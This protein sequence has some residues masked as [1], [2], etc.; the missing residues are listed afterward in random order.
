M[1]GVPSFFSGPR[2]L[3]LREDDLELQVDLPYEDELPYKSLFTAYL[4]SGVP[5]FFSGPHELD[6]RADDLELQLDPPYQD[7]L[8]YLALFT[9]YLMSGVPSLFSGPQKLDSSKLL[10]LEDDPEL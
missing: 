1:S 4:I 10:S 5:S 8:P 6:L 3:D 2:E 9:A 7:E